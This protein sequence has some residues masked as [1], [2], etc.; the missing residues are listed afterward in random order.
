MRIL[1]PCREDLECADT[2]TVIE[3]GIEDSRWTHDSRR[4]RRS[5]DS[6]RSICSGLAP[7]ADH[8]SEVAIH[9]AS[10]TQ[11]W[12]LQQ[13]LALA[14]NTAEG[15]LRCRTRVMRNSLMVFT[16]PCVGYMCVS[17]RMV[18]GSRAAG[19]GRAWVAS[20]HLALVCCCLSSAHVLSSAAEGCPVPK[21]PAGTEYTDSACKQF[22]KVDEGSVCELTCSTGHSQDPKGSYKAVCTADGTW[23]ATPN[24]RLFPAPFVPRCTLCPANFWSNQTDPAPQECTPCPPHSG[25][26][27]SGA[28][29]ASACVVWPTG[30]CECTEKDWD[31]FEDG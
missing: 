26:N 11:Q 2:R 19:V 28:E 14:V 16:V 27:E 12:V 17:S 31:D 24:G 1:S 7:S 5:L 8:D 23:K 15:E 9:A 18:V 10:H 20:A 21:P 13:D 25:T 29:S 30:L 3:T 22:S 4:V 6:L